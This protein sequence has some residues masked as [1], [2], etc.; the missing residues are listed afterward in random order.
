MLLEAY[1]KLKVDDD[2]A[3][4]VDVEGSLFRCGIRMIV[5]CFWCGERASAWLMLIVLGDQRLS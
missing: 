3:D 4:N 1:V 2:L 5:L